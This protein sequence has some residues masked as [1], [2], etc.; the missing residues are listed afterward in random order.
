MCHFCDRAG[1]KTSCDEGLGSIPPGLV[2]IGFNIPD[3][4]TTRE[5]ITLG[6]SRTERLDFPG[7]Q[8]WFRIQLSQGQLVQIDLDGT[9]ADALEDPYLRLYSQPSQL[10]A[11][12]DDSGPGLNSSL[13]YEVERT[14][15]YFIEVDS[16]AQ[17]SDGVYTLAVKSAPVTRPVDAIKGTTSIDATEPV[18]VYFAEAGD[19]Y[20]VFGTTVIAD[21]VNRYERNQLWSIF[22]GVEAFLDIDFRITTNRAA[23]DLE[24]A[25]Q[26]L[27]VFNRS[28]LGFFYFPTDDGQGHFGFLDNGASEWSNSPG[29][30]LDTGGFMYGVAIHELGHGLGLGHTH[31]TG[32]GTETLR[33]VDYAYSY[34]SHDLNQSI[35][36]AMSY[37]DGWAT[38]PNGRPFTRDYGFGATFGA[39]DIKALQETYGANTEHAAGNDIY[40]L[41]DTNGR[42]TGYRTV[43]DTGGLDQV[44]YDGA[45]DA[46]ID[47]RAAHL[48]YAEGGGG[49]VSFVDDVHAGLTIA[50][51]VLLEQASSGSGDDRLIGNAADNLLMGGAGQDTLFGGGGND[52]LD[53]G[54]GSDRLNGSTGVDLVSYLEA[55]TGISA[56]LTNQDTAAE[57]HLVDIENLKGGAFDDRLTGNDAANWIWGRHGDDGIY[58]G[59][60]D[61]TLTAQSGD[62]TLDGG[63]G[64]DLLSGGSGR[65]VFVWNSVR[66]SGRSLGIR[67]LVT[68][69]DSDGDRI[70]LSGI[71]AEGLTFVGHRLFG[72]EAAEVRYSH[73]RGRDAT[74]VDLD[75]DGDGRSDIQIEL[76]GMITLSDVNFLL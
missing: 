16:Y 21:G 59:A 31:D 23:A 52:T 14:G 40:Y 36:T 61:D 43:W 45:R 13:I 39:L 3:N 25:T 6:G 42:N 66:E 17:A 30:G 57:D 2:D 56:D 76:T 44:V 38:G 26:N 29:G 32:N 35:F 22:Q 10:V 33:G 62:D 11:F 58:G 55:D 63:F 34:G 54:A 60:G 15:T 68:D 51:G 75:A 48:T 4:N 18:Y 46:V 64:V 19:R 50:H 73:N 27:D 8:D 37:N 24:W 28:L 71:S 72:G 49:F 12:D 53:G 41:D 9:G 70:D 74:I 65:D 47:L 20:D 1:L 67:D 69:F 5:T 7:D